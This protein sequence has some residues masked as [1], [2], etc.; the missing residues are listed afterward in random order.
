MVFTNYSEGT[1]VLD[2]TTGELIATYRPGNVAAVSSDG[3][4]MLSDSSLFL[5]D[6]P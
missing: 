4:L 3:V 1:K 6:L 2:S 5:A